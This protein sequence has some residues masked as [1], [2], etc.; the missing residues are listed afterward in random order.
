MVTWEGGGGD[1]AILL[2]DPLDRIVDRI[3]P[4]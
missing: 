1:D 2:W 4:R 3:A